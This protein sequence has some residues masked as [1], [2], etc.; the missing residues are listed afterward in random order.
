MLGRKLKD[1]EESPKEISH[2]TQVDSQHWN[3][4][5][6][7]DGVKACKEANTELGSDQEEIKNLNCIEN[8]EKHI[9]IVEQFRKQYTDKVCKI[10]E[11]T[12]FFPEQITENGSSEIHETQ[13]FS[14]K[15]KIAETIAN[16]NV[17]KENRQ[18]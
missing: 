7:I 6:L 2:S 11:K 5:S 13:Y 10:T 8:W 12:Q 15:A 9:K 3:V 14:A 17:L 16:L 4:E 1:F 18:K